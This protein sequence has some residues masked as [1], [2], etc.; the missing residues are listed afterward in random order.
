MINSIELEDLGF[1]A[2]VK[3]SLITAI[4]EEADRE[5]EQLKDQIEDIISRET[6]NTAS[7]IASNIIEKFNLT[8]IISEDVIYDEVRE[9]LESTIYN[10][11][12]Y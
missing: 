7:S 3:E 1:I 11:I 9:K 4:R 12:R 6:S 2:D 8:D 5:L 10:S